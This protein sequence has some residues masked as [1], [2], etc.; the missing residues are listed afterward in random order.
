VTLEYQEMP[1]RR[2]T[3]RQMKDQS[4]IDQMRAAIRGDRER[5]LARIR[6]DGREPVF[7]RE[8]EAAEPVPE[9]TPG[10]RPAPA[11]PHAEQ[12]APV[13][14]QAEQRATEPPPAEE[15]FPEPSFF[16]RLQA[17]FRRKRFRARG[18]ESAARSETPRANGGP[19][20]KPNR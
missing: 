6:A 19:K 2:R 20:A 12:P 5:A 10:E 16:A 11:Q 18:N 14:P 7:P 17:L 9:Q 3:A 13:Q 15:P 1:P 4:Q 8:D